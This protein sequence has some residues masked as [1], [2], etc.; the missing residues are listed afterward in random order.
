LQASPD[1]IEN[2][3]A[4]LIFS[5]LLFCPWP[6]P[7]PPQFASSKGS[8]GDEGSRSTGGMSHVFARKP[9]GRLPNFRRNHKKERIRKSI[10]MYNMHKHKLKMKLTSI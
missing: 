6:P 2:S 5:N 3:V 7:F 8:E 4:H 9:Y 10:E 1:K